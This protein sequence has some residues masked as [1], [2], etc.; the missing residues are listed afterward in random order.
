[1]LFMN[2]DIKRAGG[3]RWRIANTL[4]SEYLIVIDDDVFLFPLQLKSLFEALVRDPAVP[5]GVSGM[6]QLK[7]GELQY[8]EHENI[9]VKYLCEVYA[10]T[11]NHVKRYFELE[12][13]VTEQNEIPP[14]TVEELGDYIL[15][16]QTAERDPIIHDVGR[17]FRS[18]TFKT[19][20]VAYHKQGQFE[21]VLAEV[22][23][24]VEKIRRSHT[25]IDAK[26]S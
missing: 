26:L 14:D 19:P 4:S 17:I 25:Q 7:G 9:N 1:M 5:H 6:L 21:K 24:A 10:V 20:G 16:S 23:H 13:L 22:S 11:K 18:D 12:R 15:I 2:Q 3:Y 8:H